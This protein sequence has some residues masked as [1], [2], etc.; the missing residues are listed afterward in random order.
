[1]KI[2]QSLKFKLSIIIL[3]SILL[4]FGINVFVSIKQVRKSLI[5]ISIDLAKE[6][7]NSNVS[8]IENFFI[9]KKTITWTLNQSS[10]IKDFAINTVQRNYYNQPPTQTEEELKNDWIN[11]P[12]PIKD[13]SS[14][15][16]YISLEE[17]RD[18]ILIENYNKMIKTFNTYN[19]SLRD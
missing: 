6:T 9:D 2:T 11:L 15:L 5:N 4:F 13:L 14:N 8:K 19:E 17:Q 7:L 3:I 1:M 12:Q 16:S 18:Q 10:E